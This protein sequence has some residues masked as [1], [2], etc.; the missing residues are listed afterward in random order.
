M[1]LRTKSGLPA[2]SDCAKANVLSEQFQ[3]A[4]PSSADQ[5]Y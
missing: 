3:S 4:A 1:Y 5:H 2:T